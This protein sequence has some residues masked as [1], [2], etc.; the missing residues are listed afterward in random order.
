MTRTRFQ[1]GEVLNAD[2]LDQALDELEALAGVAP[3]SL[4]AIQAASDAAAAAAAAAASS[5]TTANQAASSLAAGLSDAQTAAAAAQ[6]SASSAYTADVQ[7]LEHAQDAVSQATLADGFRQSAQ[8]SASSAYASAQLALAAATPGTNGKFHPAWRRL[9]AYGF[10]G[11]G[12]GETLAAVY[13]SLAAAR[14]VYPH[15]ASL[16]DTL[17]WAAL[18]AVLDDVAFEPYLNGVEL[19]LP[20]CDAILNRPL[21]TGARPV[22]VRGAGPRVTRLIWAADCAGW[23]HGLEGDAPV[24]YATFQMDGVGLWAS[25]PAGVALN[26][27]FH[28]GSGTF[29]LTDVVI[30]GFS[31]D[32]KWS[33]AI[34]ALGATQS[35]FTRLKTSNGAYN[36]GH[37]NPTPVAIDFFSDDES[38]KTFVVLFHDCDVS[39]HVTAVRV[40]LTGTG[41]V[42]GL[43]FDNCAGRTNNGPWMS[44]ETQYFET[45]WRPPYVVFDKCNFEG[46]GQIFAATAVSDFRMTNCLMYC[47]APIAA[48][49]PL[50]DFIKVSNASFVWLRDNHFALYSGARIDA[51]I[52]I[53]SGSGFVSLR[54]N[55]LQ[56]VA[57]AQVSAGIVIE[58]SCVDVRESGTMFLGWPGGAATIIDQSG[59]DIA[60]L[61]PTGQVFTAAGAT[62]AAAQGQAVLMLRTTVALDGLTVVLPPNPREGQRFTLATEAPITNLTLSSPFFIFNLVAG[63]DPSH[64][65]TFVY[66]RDQSYWLRVSAS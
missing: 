14:Q 43:I 7:A 21:K 35:N 29:I 47:N 5:A 36:P 27:R 51:M 8:A 13:P 50:L 19:D 63:I 41:S 26:V 31:D 59:S 57:D 55:M 44:Y 18:Q 25:V 10:L 61:A 39:A 23:E 65:L 9:A 49:S 11:D 62:V 34:N 45:Y 30:E 54:D 20:P 66:V 60:S 15:A 64:P 58:P 24:Y 33:K 3:D 46:P 4:T 42:E 53:G 38:R 6:A 40:T 17:D 1:S 16:A 48:D 52:R 32:A 22:T 37:A 12:S 28:T 2:R 56:G